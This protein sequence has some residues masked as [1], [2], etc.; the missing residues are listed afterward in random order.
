M[1]IPT[2]CTPIALLIRTDSDRVVVSASYAH[3]VL[4]RDGCLHALLYAPDDHIR[5]VSPCRGDLLWPPARW[6]SL[7]QALAD[8][9][10]RGE[11]RHHRTAPLDSYTRG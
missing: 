1:P 2:I 3:E 10:A 6:W 8:L 11:H 4:V 5:D 9:A 7:R